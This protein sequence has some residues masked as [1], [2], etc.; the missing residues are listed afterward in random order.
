ML[1]AL[2]APCDR[3][4]ED[5]LGGAGDVFEE[6]V[7]LAGERG[8]DQL[9]LLVLAADDRLQ[10]LEEAGGDVDGRIGRAAHPARVYA[11]ILQGNSYSAAG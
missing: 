9:D 4:C 8:E 6:D 2:D 10:V 1:C 11:W 5:G 3:A 7:A